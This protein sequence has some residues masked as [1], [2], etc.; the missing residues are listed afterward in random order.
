MIP[1]F[2]ASLR[3]SISHV[4][5]GIHTAF[6]GRIEK[7]DPEKNFADIQPVMKYKKPNGDLI[8]YPVLTGVPVWFPQVFGQKATIAYPIK[9][10]D[11]CLVV[12]AERPIDYWLFNRE[13]DTD[14]MFDLTEAICI[15]G[16]F[17]KPNPVV[18]KALDDEAIILQLQDTFVEIKKDDIILDSQKTL[19]V[20]TLDKV[21]VNAAKD[22]DVLS[23][24]KVNITADEINLTGTVKIVG[25]VEITGDESIVGDASVTGEIS[26]T[27]DVVAG[28]V[29]LSGHTHTTPSGGGESS[30]P[31]GGGGGGGSGSVISV[32]DEI[33]EHGG[34]IRHINAVSL[35]GDT[36]EPAHLERGYTAH[37]SYGNPITGT[38]DP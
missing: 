28:E 32:V 26:A 25:D 29:S 22:V 21:T 9:K 16:L 12:C 5:N 8:D 18:K 38:L 19:N 36:V 27:E 10:G 11:E 24:A 23:A 3:N 20:R 30:P 35:E 37:D 34:T 31:I 4:V 6:P 13:T 15:P 17:A 2:T 14:L 33:D 7:Y 1:E